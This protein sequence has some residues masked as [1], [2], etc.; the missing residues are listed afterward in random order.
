MNSV[1]LVARV[2]AFEAEANLLFA[3]FE[4]SSTARV[5]TL[6]RS[7]E[8]LKLMNLRQDD[9]FRQSLRCTEHGLYRA[10]HVMC[11]AACM[12]FIHEVLDEFGI[13]SLLKLYPKWETTKNVSE[14]AEYVPEAQLLNALSKAGLCTKNE[15][16]A[17]QG[18]L[19]K[20]NECAHPSSYL[21]GQNEALGYV[22]ECLQRM[23]HLNSKRQSAATSA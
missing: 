14:L 7:Y 21:P 11:W 23:S 2:Q 8:Q 19:N 17:L 9:L 16:K 13:K 5:M 4:T 12:D 22:S 20:R 1:D 6:E 15:V 18:L 3:T 10:A